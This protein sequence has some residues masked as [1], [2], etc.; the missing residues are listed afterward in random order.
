M[1]R[2]LFC[3]L[4]APVM[5]LGANPAQARDNTVEQATLSARHVDFNDDRQ[6]Q[7]FYVRLDAAAHKV[8]D[9]A[10]N[11]DLSVQADS[12]ECRDNALADAVRRLDKPALTRLYQANAGATPQA[13]KFRPKR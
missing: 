5:V 3:V 12:A 7:A 1:L 10:P 6:A 2:Y 13:V 9:V 11:N 8:C 4:L